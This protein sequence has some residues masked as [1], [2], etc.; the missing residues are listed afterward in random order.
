MYEQGVLATTHLIAAWC[1][2]G[3]SW[4]EC[5]RWLVWVSRVR[6]V[7]C[8]QSAACCSGGC[9]D[10]TWELKIKLQLTLWYRC[11]VDSSSSG[12]KLTRLLGILARL[13]SRLPS[14]SLLDRLRRIYNGP[15]NCKQLLQHVQHKQ[16]AAWTWPVMQ[17]RVDQEELWTDVPTPGP[18]CYSAKHCGQSYTNWSKI[19][20]HAPFDLGLMCMQARLVGMPG[21]NTFSW[22]G[23]V[24][25]YSTCA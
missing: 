2:W 18:P 19:P 13:L 20:Q 9:A 22:C 17:W 5:C 24:D 6:L 10:W 21:Q 3:C 7:A 23:W 11:I 25:T 4:V 14:F 15:G 16:G 12:A 1:G 8:R